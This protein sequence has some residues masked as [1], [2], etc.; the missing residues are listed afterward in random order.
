MY[1]VKHITR[2]MK[3]RPNRWTNLACIYDTFP[4]CIVNKQQ[5]YTKILKLLE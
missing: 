5:C 3:Q 1:K 2:L 4:F